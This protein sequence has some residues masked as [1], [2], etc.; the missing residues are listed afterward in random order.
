MACS[1][2]TGITST[3]GPTPATL[4]QKVSFIAGPGTTNPCLINCHTYYIRPRWIPGTPYAG[5]VDTDFRRIWVQKANSAEPTA[6]L[7]YNDPSD[8]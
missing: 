7:G 6:W 2:T 3:A 5:F 4:N 8:R 1:S